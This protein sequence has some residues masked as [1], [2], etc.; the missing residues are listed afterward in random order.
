MK[1]RPANGSQVTRF[2][3]AH[4]RNRPSERCCG[5]EKGFVNNPGYLVHVLRRRDYII[6]PV[7][8]PQPEGAFLGYDQ[9]LLPPANRPVPNIKAL[10]STTCWIASV[11]VSWE[12]V[13]TVGP[14]TEAVRRYRD[15]IRDA[16]AP[17][18]DTLYRRG[19]DE[20]QYLPPRSVADR[21]ALRALCTEMVRFENHFLRHYRTYLLDELRTGT[22]DHRL[23]AA[24][25]LAEVIY[26]DDEVALALTNLADSDDAELRATV[27][28]YWERRTSR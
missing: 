15:T 5:T 2:P 26:P 8:H 18:V 11:L 16:W 20:W 24:S 25:R 19:K 6:Y 17:F 10:V 27:A 7:A 28:L 4:D 12:T 13:A 3:L 23:T 1:Q 14:R 22:R 21:R 9:P